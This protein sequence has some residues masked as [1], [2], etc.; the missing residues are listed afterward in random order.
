MASCDVCG[1]VASRAK[2]P[3]YLADE[4]R[5]LVA[6]GFGPAPATIARWAAEQGVTEAAALAGWQ[7]KV[8]K[9]SSEWLLCASCAERTALYR[10]APEKA[11]ESVARG[12]LAE[13]IIN[14]QAPQYRAW[15]SSV[16]QPTRGP[17]SRMHRPPR[18]EETATEIRATE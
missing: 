5:Q 14:A 3:V 1:A 9:T 7:G 16:N 17:A 11:M 4:F 10:K 18:T 15:G 12:R 2:N 13:R 6:N 8:A